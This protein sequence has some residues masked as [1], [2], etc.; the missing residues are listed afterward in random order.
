MDPEHKPILAYGLPGTVALLNRGFAD[1][2]VPIEFTE[3]S[4]LHM[5]VQDGIDPA[6]SH[7]ILDGGQAVG[8]ALIAR[9]GWTCRLAALVVVPE[10]RRQGIGRWTMDRL[11][12]EAAQ[13]GEKRMVLEVIEQ[14]EP[15][16]SLYRGGGFRVLRRLVGYKAIPGGGAGLVPAREVDVREVDVREAARL[17]TAYGLPDLPW[18]VSGES[19]ALMSPPNRAYRLG[20]AYVV[21]SNPVSPQI[22]IRSVVV[23][24]EARGEGLA[25]RLLRTL[26]D[27]HPD[28]QWVVP[29]LCPQEIGGLFERVGF[30]R[31][32]L[33]QLQMVKRTRTEPSATTS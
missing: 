14:N 30:E 32:E 1:Y 8:V 10:A 17:V 16:V 27:N 4:L 2:V 13:R 7:V 33:S 20:E 18:Q 12:E 3:A 22:A 25:A 31:R 21:I 15:A 6:S 11:I 28:A 9:R 29:A 19:L 23:K 5:V 24:P 26:M